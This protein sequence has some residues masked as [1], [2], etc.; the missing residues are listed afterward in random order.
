MERLVVNHPIYLLGGGGYSTMHHISPF[1]E[2]CQNGSLHPTMHRPSPLP[3]SGWTPV[4]LHNMM[5]DSHIYAAFER[6]SGLQGVYVRVSLSCFY[7][8]APSEPI[9]FYVNFPHRVGT[10]HVQLNRPNPPF[11]FEFKWG[12]ARQVMHPK[13]DFQVGVRA[14]SFKHAWGGATAPRSGRGSL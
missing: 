13:S 2:S 9:I 12:G 8:K 3:D 14:S 6:K 10:G 5:P 7:T 4:S 11:P 1:P